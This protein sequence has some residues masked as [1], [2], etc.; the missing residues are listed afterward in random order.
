MNRGE[1]ASWGGGFEK[2]CK[3]GGARIFSVVMGCRNMLFEKSG[4]NTPNKSPAV[5]EKH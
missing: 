4:S 2:V 1:G 3:R 5:D